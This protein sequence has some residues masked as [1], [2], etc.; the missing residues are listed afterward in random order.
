VWRWWLASGGGQPESSGRN[1]GGVGWS[2]CSWKRKKKKSAERRGRRK[3]KV[4]TV[5]TERRCLGGGEKEKRENSLQKQRKT[6]GGGWFFV[7]FE[8]DFL[9]HEGMK[10][11]SIYRRWKRAIVSTL[12]KTFSPWFS[13]EGSQLLVQSRH[14]EL[15]NLQEKAAWVGLFRSASGPSYC[16]SAWTVHM[17][18]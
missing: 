14:P 13:W 3:E 8:L 9:F 4:A 18:L 16:H 6:E 11:T 12:E 10:S 7:N 1:G 5:V 17:G 15:L 2:G